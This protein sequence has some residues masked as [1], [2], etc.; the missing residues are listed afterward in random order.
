MATKD[1]VIRLHLMYPQLNSVQIAERLGC[2]DAYVRATFYRNGLKLAGSIGTRE[3]FKL[4]DLCL[5]LGLAEAD[6][7]RLAESKKACA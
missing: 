3:K 7:Y 5:S 6:L 2:D 4:G 1:Q